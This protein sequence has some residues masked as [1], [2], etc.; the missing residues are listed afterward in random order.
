[1]LHQFMRV[2]NNSNMKL[3]NIAVIPVL[4]TV[5]LYATFWN[6]NSSVWAVW[7]AQAIRGKKW[8]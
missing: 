1:M 8:I 7:A 5:V 4:Y 6:M 2:R 3:V